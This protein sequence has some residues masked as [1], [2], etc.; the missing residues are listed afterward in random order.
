MIK[1]T[2]LTSFVNLNWR[3]CRRNIVWVP[4]CNG[5][6]QKSSL[7]S[8]LTFQWQKQPPHH[9]C[10]TPNSNKQS[11]GKKISHFAIH[12]IFHH[13]HNRRGNIIKGFFK[14]A[15]VPFIINTFA[16]WNLFTKPVRISPVCCAACILMDG[17]KWE[18]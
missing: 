12:L 11:S 15:K 9:S 17:H 2:T 16:L 18:N 3:T 6:R 14:G 5:G 1:H 8:S 10:T 4:D 13:V 7:H